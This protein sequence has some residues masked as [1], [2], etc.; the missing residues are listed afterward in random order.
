[1]TKHL[2]EKI[3]NVCRDRRMLFWSICIIKPA[4]DPDEIYEELME[5]KE[6]VAPY[7]CDVSAYLWEAMQRRQRRS[8]WRDSLVP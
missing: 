8:C 1:M 4:L 6:M 5:Y 2:R 7:V 3:A